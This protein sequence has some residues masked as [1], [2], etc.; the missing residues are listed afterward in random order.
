MRRRPPDARPAPSPSGAPDLRQLTAARFHV[1]CIWSAGK[2]KVD[3]SRLDPCDVKKKTKCNKRDACVWVGK[4]CMPKGEGSTIIAQLEDMQASGIKD[5]AMETLL[6]Q[7]IDAAQD[8]L[9]TARP[10]SESS[11]RNIFLPR[12]HSAASGGVTTS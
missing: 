11:V 7:T 5:E 12:V 6:Q 1:G 3:P 8:G 2:C 10:R 4:A 9:E